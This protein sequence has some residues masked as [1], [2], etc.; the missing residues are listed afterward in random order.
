MIWYLIYQP[1]GQILQTGC[2]GDDE[3][4]IQAVP[5]GARIVRVAGQVNPSTHYYHVSNRQPEPF[6]ERP[7]PYHTFDFRAKVWRDRRDEDQRTLDAQDEARAARRAAYP[8]VG[9]QLDQLWKAMRD[10]LLPKV[11]PWYSQIE[12][13]KADNPIP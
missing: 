3:L 13:I 4:G 6:P 5:E 1:P 7:S 12:A 8:S 2:C 9:D 11:E 10:G